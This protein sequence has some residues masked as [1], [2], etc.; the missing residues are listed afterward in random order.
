MYL[1]KGDQVEI[2][3]DTKLAA[4]WCKIRYIGK[5]GKP[6]TAWMQSSTLE[7]SQR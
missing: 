1:V 6:I 5:S 2:I 7:R 3:D 4:G